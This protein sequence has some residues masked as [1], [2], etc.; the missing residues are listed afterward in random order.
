LKI[1]KETD[2]NNP[3]GFVK[4]SETGSMEFMYFKDY[5]EGE[6][7]QIVFKPFRK[8]F[9]GR[10]VEFRFHMAY[11]R[12]PTELRY[13]TYLNNSFKELSQDS[14]CS[15]LILL[16]INQ[17]GDGSECS[18]AYFDIDKEDFDT[19][20]EDLKDEFGLE[21]Y[22]P[23]NTVENISENP[24]MKW[25]N[26]IHGC[27]TTVYVGK[28]KPAIFK[29]H[30]KEKTVSTSFLI[31]TLSVDHTVGFAETNDVKKLLKYCKDIKKPVEDVTDNRF[32]IKNL[33]PCIYSPIRFTGDYG[34]SILLNFDKG[35]RTGYWPMK[36]QE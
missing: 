35:W 17:A 10:N 34:I 15:G 1:G 30:Q 22:A 6:N 20:I 4:T 21:Q 28:D 33:L 26:P 32:G 14:V 3:I 12:L 8:E 29:F 23:W 24:D 36:K 25:G 9:E 13:L 16:N 5:Y 27:R 11:L 31:L 2:E 18:E 19:E 7:G